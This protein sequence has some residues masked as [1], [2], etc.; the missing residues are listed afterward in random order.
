M[1]ENP[2]AFIN[3]KLSKKVLSANTIRDAMMASFI[4]TLQKKEES[5]G[6]V[7]GDPGKWRQEKAGEMR[8]VASEAFGRIG[9]P[10]EYPTLSQMEQVKSEIERHYRWDRL[11]PILRDEHERICRLLFSKFEEPF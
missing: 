1:Y 3:E 7:I 10:F 11:P 4:L 9:A 8:K 2:S 5:A 6:A